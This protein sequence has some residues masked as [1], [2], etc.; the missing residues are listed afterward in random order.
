MTHKIEGAPKEEAAISMHGIPEA[1]G[2]EARLLTLQEAVR[3]ALYEEMKRD[4]RVLLIG[5]DIGK[6]GG[7]YGCTKGLYDEFGG[8][9]VRDAPISEGAI[10]G[11]AI[12]AAATGMRP[13][14]EI[15]YV[16]WV[17]AGGAMEQI[18]NQLAKIPY[19]G[20]GQTK[21]PVVVRMA[22]GSRYPAVSNGPH[23]NQCLEAWFVHIPGLRVA[24]PS[25]PYDA[26]G[27]L[28]TA[29]RDDNPTIFFEHKLLYYARHKLVGGLYPSM[30]SHVPEEEYLIP[31]G[32]ADVK[33]D[34][35][36][37]TVVATMAM[38]HKALKAAEGLSKQGISVEIIDPRTLVPLD[39]QTIVDSI[40]KTGRAIVT[41]EDW[42][43]CGVA[44][45]ITS[46]IIEEAFD[47]LDAPVRRV[48]ALDLPLSYSHVLEG[49]VLPHEEDIVK[50]VRAT[51]G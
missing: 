17:A 27:L 31:F 30:V 8:E 24:A 6:Y 38:V 1:R 46:V 16:D 32:K 13:M 23:H 48:S 37:V 21:L 9:R 14:A 36:D 29:I 7:I 20:A 35:E 42:K 12:G 39:K 40:K 22:C 10:I 18:F 41:S 47:Y 34:G 4:G 45:E 28:K 3:E 50:A 25:T 11:A 33:R 2:A 5:E 15:M 26:K 51:M 43:T 49:A 44:A 19:I